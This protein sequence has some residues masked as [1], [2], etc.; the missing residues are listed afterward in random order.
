MLRRVLLPQ[1]FNSQEASADWD[2]KVSLPAD[3]MQGQEVYTLESIV[4]VEGEA[5]TSGERKM[6]E[7]EKPT[8]SAH[9]ARFSPDDKYSE[10]RCKK[11]FGV[12]KTQASRLEVFA[13][14]DVS[15]GSL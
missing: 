3:S 13:S 4:K 14:S 8:F 6:Q 9:P 11:R 15:A 12:L 10:H 5:P 7:E 2:P 1:H